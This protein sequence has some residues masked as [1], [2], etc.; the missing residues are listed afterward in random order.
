MVWV[1]DL[2]FSFLSFFAVLKERKLYRGSMRKMGSSSAEDIP[3]MQEIVLE[4][5]AGKMVFYGKKVVPDSR[6]GLVRIGRVNQALGRV[7]ILKF[8]TDDRKSLFGCRSGSFSEPKAKDDS[9]LC[10]S[11]KYYI[12]HPFEFLD[13]EE[14]DA[15]T[16]SQVF[17]DM[18]EDNISS[19]NGNLIVPDLGA[20]VMSDVTSSS[21][22]MKLEDL[23]R[24]LSNIGAGGS[25][26]D[27]DK[28]DISD[29]LQS[30]PFRQQEDSF[31][32]V[33]RTGQID[34]SQF[35]INPSKCEWSLAPEP[36]A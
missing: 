10:R 27:P 6:K 30:R 36:V 5:R 21:G 7:Y 1:F 33:L 19:R 32:Y 15:S 28:E 8:N 34:L 18:L 14:P 12:N 13:K 16:P 3:A 25:S 17:E 31:T 9:Q 22:P 23:Q 24:I 11:V 4:F 20:E 2:S 29:L 35:E 26:G